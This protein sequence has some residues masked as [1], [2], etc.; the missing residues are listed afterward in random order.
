[1]DVDL[2]VY[3]RYILNVKQT[4]D[5]LAENLVGLRGFEVA[6]LCFTQMS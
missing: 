6:T 1:M 5:V 3:V 4:L 2:S